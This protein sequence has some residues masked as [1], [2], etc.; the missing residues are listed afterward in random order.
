MCPSPTATSG[1]SSLRGQPL[2]CHWLP[3]M[4][5][6]HDCLT[7]LDKGNEV[8]ALLFDIKIAFDSVPHRLFLHKLQ[9]RGLDAYLLRWI[10]G[11]LTDRTQAVVLNGTSLESLSVLSAGS[12]GLHPWTPFIHYLYEWYNSIPLGGKLV[13]YADDIL[14]YRTIKSKEDYT[15]HFKSI[16]MPWMTTIWILTLPNVNLW[17]PGKEVTVPLNIHYF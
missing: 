10:S 17:C 1:V 4:T 9:G 15:W 5:A 7:E 3:L 11:C 8:A 13:L 14:L 2:E 12:P 6:T 16:W